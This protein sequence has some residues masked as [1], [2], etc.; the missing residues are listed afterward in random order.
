MIRFGPHIR[1]TRRETERF[2]LITDLEPVGIRTLPD[3]DAYIA[4]C[5]AHYWGVSRDTQFLHWLIDREYQ[6][7]RSAA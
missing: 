2:K 3:L 1:L 5:K 4:Q 6:Q 7:C